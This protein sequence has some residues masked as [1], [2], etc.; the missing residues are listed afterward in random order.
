MT[1]LSLFFT[2]YGRTRRTVYWCG[3]IVDLLVVGTV[4]VIADSIVLMAEGSAFALIMKQ[5]LLATATIAFALSM[6][7]LH[8]R[9]MH[10][11]GLTGWLG[12]AGFS[13]ISL[14]VY[15]IGRPLVGALFLVGHS[16]DD[17]LY[18]ALALCLLGFILFH[19]GVVRG[20][21]GA[22]RFGPDPLE[23]EAKATS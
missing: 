13:A 21:D 4:L 15:W 2:Y 11:R 5:G 9:R 12:L 8:V 18:A 16:I 1:F 6:P 22:N 7:S 17:L 23:Q 3:V 14:C 19:F 10:D 20:Q